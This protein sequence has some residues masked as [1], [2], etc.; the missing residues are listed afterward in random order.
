[1]GPSP[2]GQGP[3][4]R[5]PAS[6]LD[7]GSSPFPHA[8]PAAVANHLLSVGLTLV[9]F[10]I[11][12]STARLWQFNGPRF[13]PSGSYTLIPAL[14]CAV[15]ALWSAR[16]TATPLTI[17][18]LGGAAGLLLVFISDWF[19]RSYNFFPNP[20]VRGEILLGGGLLL[21]L[22][23]ALIV[24]VAKWLPWISAAVLALVFLSEGQGQLLFSDDHPS[25][26]FRLSLLREQFPQI[27]FYYP[28]W[29]AGLDARDFFATGAIGVFLL[30]S[31]VLYALDPSALLSGTVYNL[32]VA[33]LLFLVVPA[34]MYFAARTLRVSPLSRALSA[35][36]ALCLGLVWY[37][38]ALKYGT[39]G[40]VLS[41]ALVPLNFSL[42]LSLLETGRY[43]SWTNAWPRALALLIG[44]TLMLFWSPS[45]LV[46]VPM[47]IGMTAALIY[48]LVKRAPLPTELIVTTL[49][50]VVLNAPWIALFWSVSD[51][52]RF[53]NTA[54]VAVRASEATIG[55]S[56][57]TNLAP[58]AWEIRQIEPRAP[59]PSASEPAA[60]EPSA[61]RGTR[62]RKGEMDLGKSLAL[63]REK[64]FSTNPLILFFALPGI[65]LL[66]PQSRWFMLG[67]SAWL[68]FLGSVMVPVKPQL[69]LDRMLLILSMLLCLPCGL[70]IAS[71]LERRP[72]N[73]FWARLLVGG[74][75]FVSPFCSAA[76][77]SN[78]TVDQYHF[79]GPFLSSLTEAIRRH[80]GDGRVVFS[81]CIVHEVE[82]GHIAPLTLMTGKEIVA[83]A[84]FHTLWRYT[85]VVPKSFME[86]GDA[87]IED[88]LDQMNASAVIAHEREWREYFSRH[89]ERYQ[90]VWREDR[91][92]LYTRQSNTLSPFISGAGSINARETA[93]L[94]L[95]LTTP[96]AT[97]KYRYFPF[98]QVDLTEKSAA[99]H[100]CRI[101]PAQV[102]PEIAFIELRDCPLNTELH[103]HAGSPW[104]R[105]F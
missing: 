56:E 24:R 105:V 18:P 86:R 28:F 101:L 6:G 48:R 15:L 35:L 21:L 11:I 77:L 67:T 1:M 91:F 2:A 62:H 36:L 17:T 83:S 60:L 100:T 61:H 81:G 89:P 49:A 53:L 25:F 75:L 4:D 29:N 3:G 85:Q 16:R 57:S 80:G 26:L 99:P 88:Y 90:L 71:L 7:E 58:E 72:E 19:D 76:V 93:G 13:I 27:P 23:N 70:A 20:S 78:R 98:L 34:C 54:T 12:A 104:K 44:S 39:M 59:E 46:F 94:R 9:I 73:P 65:F 66:R 96:S 95:T 82:E 79:A 31:P 32:I 42:A 38:W 103:I 102:A 41:T 43:L 55:V 74:F 97:I 68:L 22:G 84:P 14:A 50:V 69:E 5:A 37:R 63:L 30:F 40:F 51:V 10:G 64:S 92:S 47:A 52:G 45:G 8:Q 87:G 33:T